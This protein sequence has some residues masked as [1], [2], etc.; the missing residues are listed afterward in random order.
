MLKNLYTDAVET[1]NLPSFMEV[2]VRHA[3]VDGDKNTKLLE[4]KAYFPGHCVFMLKY[5]YS[6]AQEANLWTKWI[7][8]KSIY[9]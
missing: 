1:T 6:T 8:S 9:K 4:T 3:K 2:S 5:L 7:L